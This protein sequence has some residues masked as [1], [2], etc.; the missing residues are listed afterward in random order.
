MNISSKRPHHSV[1]ASALTAALLFTVHTAVAQE[2]LPNFKERACKVENTN[3]NKGFG[4]GLRYFEE[5]APYLKHLVANGG[6]VTFDNLSIGLSPDKSGMY[7]YWRP[8]ET[9]L[10]LYG[11]SNECTISSGTV[12]HSSTDK[13][14][15]SE[16]VVYKNTSRGCCMVYMRYI[17]Q[18]IATPLT[19]SVGEKSDDLRNIGH[20]FGW[21]DEKDC[22]VR[23]NRPP[24]Y[25]QSIMA[26][27][28]TYAASVVPGGDVNAW[29]M[30]IA[31]NQR[32]IL[33]MDAEHGGTLSA[34]CKD[35]PHTFSKR[36]PPKPFPDVDDLPPFPKGDSFVPYVEK[37][38]FVWPVIKKREGPGVP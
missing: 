9:S 15:A 33:R 26:K 11:Y 12:S 29:F 2:F 3:P 4:L 38:E 16:G 23:V 34:T 6:Q 35:L 21:K 25:N 5:G 17:Y 24:D 19:A 37:S 10:F 36:P 7:F 18:V 20:V 32:N 27:P 1:L 8:A 13:S 28:Q 22:S 31:L 30:P 14:E